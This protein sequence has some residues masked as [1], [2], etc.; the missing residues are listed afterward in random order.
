MPDLSNYEIARAFREPGCPLCR[1][2]AADEERSMQQFWRDSRLLPRVRLRF[3]ASGG[4][5]RRHAWLMHDQVMRATSRG[6]VLTDIYGAMVARDLRRIAMVIDGGRGRIKLAEGLGALAHRLECRA[7]EE[8]AESTSRRAHF[9]CQL[10]REKGMVGSYRASDGLCLP[11]LEAVLHRCAEDEPEL[12]RVLLA[13][14]SDRLAALQGQLA[15]FERKRDYRHADELRGDEQRA[16]SDAVRRY[17]GE[18]NG[19]PT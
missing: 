9:F 13:D 18:P 1:V 8:L 16:P 15:E 19:E 6:G 7:C 14:W 11:H 3:F 2:V 17:A 12:G 10:L 4:F 5:C